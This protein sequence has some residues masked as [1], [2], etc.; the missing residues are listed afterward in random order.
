MGLGS[1]AIAIGLGW[2]EPASAF[3]GPIEDPDALAEQPA[4]APLET[5][6]ED[7]PVG[8]FDPMVPQ[9]VVVS[10]ALS[11]DPGAT[12]L[13]HDR[14]SE[15]VVTW[16]G[17]DD[18][19]PR[20]TVVVQ[21][22]EREV[23]TLRFTLHDRGTL[24]A[25]RDFA[26]G[27]SRCDDLHS[28]VALAIALALDATVLDSVGVTPAPV[29]D[30]VPPPGLAPPSV[31]PRARPPQ[32]DP[33][34]TSPPD[35]ELDLSPREH[36]W[37]I[38]TRG[39]GLLTFGAPP[40]VGGGAELSVEA[41]WHHLI[42]LQLGAFAT[43]AGPQRVEDTTLDVILAAGRADLCG[44]PQL[45]LVRPRVCGGVIA[46]T[47]VAEGNGF[48]RDFRISVPWVAFAFGGD[49]RVRLS[50]RIRLSIGL[51]GLVT[52]VQPV[53]E[54]REE[55]GVRQLRDL[56]RFGAAFGVGLVLVLR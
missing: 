54:V 3:V 44:G 17:R 24:I 16:L 52:A 4:E 33:P 47:A 22:D 39:R 6:S 41:G 21:G 32:P 36:E 50:R 42:D 2:A 1:T 31:V 11:L 46:G 49:L 48:V 27:P 10:E 19:D 38:R 12:C 23:R 18:V 29:T 9:Q 55:L 25:E 43:S 53:F 8:T 35:D 14:L 5:P 56:P 51:D 37:E 45:G 20:L 13:E 30:P 7:A 28:V 26:P 15:Q 40:T 34:S